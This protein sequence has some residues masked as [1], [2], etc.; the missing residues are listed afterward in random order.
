M[1]KGERTSIIRSTPKN[2]IHYALYNSKAITHSPNSTH[3]T[4]PDEKKI[5]TDV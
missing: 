1:E 3:Y 2:N 5:A 4:Q